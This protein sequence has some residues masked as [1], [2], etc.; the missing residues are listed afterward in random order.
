MIPI[1]L[2][3]C[4][5]QYLRIT[6]ESQR[7][8]TCM[9]LTYWSWSTNQM[10]WYHSYGPIMPAPQLSGA[11]VKLADQT[12]KH[13][14][15]EVWSTMLRPMMP[16]LW[17]NTSSNSNWTRCNSHTTSTHTWCIERWKQ[18]CSENIRKLLG[19]HTKNENMRLN[20]TEN[21]YRVWNSNMN[22][23]E[24]FSGS[25]CKKGHNDVKCLDHAWW[26]SW[27]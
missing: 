19:L 8:V 14:I 20:E 23:L 13:D 11:E 26:E 10:P 12:Y 16:C 6:H 17:S 3:T 7:L 18:N 5:V 22:L 21:S 15:S 24:C 27:W 4:N 2:V 1:K 25:L 9:Y